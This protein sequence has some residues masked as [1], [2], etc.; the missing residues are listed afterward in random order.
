MTVQDP[1]SG[2]D[3]RASDLVRPFVMTGG[4]TRSS[5]D[6]IRVETIVEQ[7]AGGPPANL[8]E[9]VAI[10][11]SCGEEPLS[12]AEISSHTGLALGVVTILVGDL[13]DAGTLEMHQTDPV[14]IE[15]STLTRMIE[16]VRAL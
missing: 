15:V 4:R 14:D 7:V 3:H 2:Y 16:R 11:A 6:D 1:E 8:P 13:I 12:V 5:R 10:L 9:Q